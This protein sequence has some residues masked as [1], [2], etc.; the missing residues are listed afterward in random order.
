MMYGVLRG[1]SILHI[2]Q[3]DIVLCGENTAGIHCTIFITVCFYLFIS[4]L[5]WIRFK[6]KIGAVR[7]LDRVNEMKDLM[8]DV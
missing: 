6:E 1:K 5:N 8:I 3:Y 4:S 7:I 2:D